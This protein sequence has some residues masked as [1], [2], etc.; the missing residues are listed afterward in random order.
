MRAV[1]TVYRGRRFRSRLEARFA[2]ELDSRGI[3]WHYEPKRVGKDE[4]YLVDFYLPDCRCWV[5]VKGKFNPLDLEQIPR[6]GQHL[7][8]RGEELF[9][10][11]SDEAYQVNDSMKLI[12]HERLW[13]TLTSLLKV[14]MHTQAP[15]QPVSADS[16]S[17]SLPAKKRRLPATP[18]IYLA[19][20][21]FLLALLSGLPY[22]LRVSSLPPS[23]T[24]SE[25][26]Q[27][28]PTQPAAL[29]SQY[30]PKVRVLID[31][32]IVRPAPGE[33]STEVTQLKQGT[34]AIILAYT[35]REEQG[36]TVLWWQIETAD[37]RSGWAVN[38]LEYIQVEGVVFTEGKPNNVNQYRE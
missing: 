12:T 6:I 36:E 17:R 19:R 15:I 31:W 13:L 9:V 18:I 10:F 22:L 29:T 7:L 38:N 4:Q 34:E 3:H 32:L 26:Q 27:P 5:E 23:V 21:G 25:V 14:P 30:Q 1:P 37:G 33:R 28:A 11:M 8:A 24:Q 20:V 16:K 35:V 2:A